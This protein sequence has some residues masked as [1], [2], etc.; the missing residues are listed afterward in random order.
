LMVAENT[1]FMWLNCVLY[2][3]FVIIRAG[4]RRLASREKNDVE[5]REGTKGKL[6]LDG[7][8]IVEVGIFLAYILY[9]IHDPE[10]VPFS[11]A[12]YVSLRVVGLIVAAAG[13]GLLVWVHV[14]LGKN[15]S[16]HILIRAHQKMI[17]DGPYRLVRHPMYSAFIIFNIGV[18]IASANWLIALTWGI[19]LFV[20]LVYRIPREEQALILKFGEVY[21]KYKRQ[22]GLLAPKLKKFH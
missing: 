18:M 13:L 16:P 17:Q 8:I 7:L 15:F 11:T 20:T 9:T 10:A 4:F 6:I 21:V 14:H 3:V 1:L 2:S 12:N 19:G 22:T 5:Y